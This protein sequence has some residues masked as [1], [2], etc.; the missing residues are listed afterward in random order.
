MKNKPFFYVILFVLLT[1]V[2]GVARANDTTAS[3]LLS[4]QTASA[5]TRTYADTAF[6]DFNHFLRS[7]AADKQFKGLAPTINAYLKTKANQPLHKSIYRL[8]GLYTQLKYGKE[9]IE[10]LRHLVSIPTFRVDT[11]PPHENPHIITIGKAIGQIAKDFNLDF[12]NADNRVFVVS[13][14]NGQGANVGLHAHADVVPVNKSAWVLEDGTQLDPFTLT[15]IG[16]R[17]YG[18]GTEDDKNGIVAALYAMKVI[19]EEG[20]PLRNTVSLLV[21]TT[22][23]SG[24]DAIRYYL[25]KNPVPDYNIALD[26]NYPVVIAEKGYGTVMATFPIRKGEGDGAEIVSITGGLATNQIPPKSIATFISQSPKQLKAQL[27]N[28]AK[29]F[30][31]KHGDNFTVESRVDGDKVLL[32]VNGISAHSSK[33]ASGINPVSR[34]WALIDAVRHEVAIQSNHI[35]DAARYAKD[36]WGMNYHGKVL[37]IDFSD[38]FMGPLTSA[39]TYINISDT[40]LQLAV[41]IRMPKGKTPEQLQAE[42]K[43][44]L[45]AWKKDSGIAVVIKHDQRAPM[46]RNP[47]GEWVRILLDV[48]SGN[49]GITRDF[50]SSSGSTTI[51]NLPNGVQFG[52]ALPTERYT[53]HNANEF[54]RVDQ[55]LID[56]TIVTEMAGRLGSLNMAQ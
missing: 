16:N 54:K 19:K 40:Q 36:N 8:L 42:V 46:Y 1:L 50:G 38:E 10:M 6:K 15:M 53:G 55:F 35:T 32:T 39:L 14:N 4:K 49:L 24:A 3:A 51:H 26:G 47:D 7:V 25:K 27:D 33:P 31:A 2:T 48:A 11:I 9:A 56:M 29:R 37:G 5:I 45:D 21:D 44:K 18:R 22:E 13:I 28:V 52:L 34:M 20:I 23:E 30:I 43:T 41:N 17:M 12:Y